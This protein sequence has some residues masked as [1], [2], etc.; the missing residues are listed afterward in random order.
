MIYFYE[1][2][3][4][5]FSVDEFVRDYEECYY[6]PNEDTT[7]NYIPGVS[8][9]SRTA[10]RKIESFL[11]DGF[12]D[13]K[14]V[15][16][17]LAWKIGGID[18]KSSNE[19]IYFKDNWGKADKVTERYFECGRKEYNELCERIA[20]LSV[21]NG[22][23]DETLENILSVI[24]ETKAKGFGPVYILTLL[25][26]VTK[27]ESPIFDRY[28][29]TAVKAIYNGVKPSEIW[30]ENPSSKDKK[31]LLKL[32]NEYRWYLVQ[33]FGRADIE[34][35]IDRSLWVYGHTK[36]SNHIFK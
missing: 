9:N 27:K 34:R 5:T 16:T 28:A 7:K 14:D 12:Q 24:D 11:V 32:I 1:R 10:E 20:Q 26:F 35:R 21:A 6:L 25:Y 3:P 23:I 33:V 19:G 29:Y 31:N 13:G 17:A 22:E 15:N 18:N 8:I 4:K 36:S 2:K 30:Y